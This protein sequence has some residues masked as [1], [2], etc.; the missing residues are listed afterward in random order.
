MCS[1]VVCR[2]NV[3]FRK[4]T[5]PIEAEMNSNGADDGDS[6][7]SENS[8]E[9]ERICSQMKKLKEVIECKAMENI[10]EAQDRYKRDYD[11][12]HHTSKVCVSYVCSIMLIVFSCPIRR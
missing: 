2:F 4:A 7:Q 12:K 6:H 8:E 11:K 1:Y 5:L 9:R 10:E 3:N